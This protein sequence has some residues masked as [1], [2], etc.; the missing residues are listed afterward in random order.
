MEKTAKCQN[1]GKYRQINLID[2]KYTSIGCDYLNIDLIEK[3]ANDPED[4]MVLKLYNARLSGTRAN[5]KGY[6]DQELKKF[7]EHYRKMALDDLEHAICGKNIKSTDSFPSYDLT[8]G[9]LAPFVSSGYSTYA[10][11]A[12]VDN[13]KRL[14]NNDMKRA[15]NSKCFIDLDHLELSNKFMHNP[16]TYIRRT[17]KPSKSSIHSNIPNRTTFESKFDKANKTGT[18]LDI[19]NCNASG[20]GAVNVDT[21]KTSMYSI[22]IPGYERLIYYAKISSKANTINKSPS[23][24]PA[25]VGPSHALLHCIKSYGIDRLPYNLE[26]VPS[27]ISKYF[28]KSIGKQMSERSKSNGTILN[29]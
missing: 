4:K 7:G 20:D 15:Y 13:S 22:D 24:V 19:S 3:H 12:D 5:I 18:Y 23:R 14:T 27:N 6:L 26:P 21:K 16:T 1:E 8:M 28:A 25:L 2:G 11:A 9:G 10:H 29:R 17:A